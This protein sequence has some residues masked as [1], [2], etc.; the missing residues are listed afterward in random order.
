MKNLYKIFALLF[1][2][3]L[4]IVACDEV[5]LDDPSADTELTEDNALAMQ[6]LGDVF[7]YVNN[8]NSPGKALP[9]CVTVLYV[10]ETKTLTID[11]GPEGCLGDDGVVRKGIITAVFTGA[12][13]GWDLGET[14]T[15][16]FTDYYSNEIKLE[17]GITIT[18][19]QVEML[20]FTIVANNMVLTFANEKTINWSS[21]E[22][23]TLERTD[24]SGEYWRFNGSTTGTC[25]ARSG[26]TFSR[27]TTNLLSSPTCKWFIDGSI[28]ITAGDNITTVTFLSECG[29]IKI[30]RN[31]LPEF[32]FTL[33]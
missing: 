3:G 22:T 20:S 29:K 21:S 23:I 28:T 25:T 4:F 2:M 31:Q 10:V 26:K 6:G 16:T 11:F 13:R 30:K 24:E 7:A 32:E 1:A 18:R 14:A 27:T 19:N 9:E 15:I 17:G 12:T 33:D 8:G 5:K